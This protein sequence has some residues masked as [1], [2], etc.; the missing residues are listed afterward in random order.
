ML[1]ERFRGEHYKPKAPTTPKRNPRATQLAMARN[2]DPSTWATYE[3]AEQTAKEYGCGIGLMLGPADDG[4]NLVAF[5]LDDCRNPETG[6]I[7]PWAWELIKECGSYVEITPSGTGL[8]IIGRGDGT[9]AHFTLR[10]PDD[11]HVEVY[12][13]ATR[14]ITVTGQ[15]LE[16][17]PDE[18]ADISAV[19]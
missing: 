4:F 8:R 6:E 17:T 12:S 15:Q 16:G 7:A 11:A 18:L 13:K 2:N 14:Y 1:P 3:Q 9:E 5:D 19:V 10:R